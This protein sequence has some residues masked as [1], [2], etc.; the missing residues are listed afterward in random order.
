MKHAIKTELFASRAPLEWAVVGN[1]TLY[2]AQIPIDTQ[3]Q[4]VAGGIEAQARQTLDNLRH[5]LEAA[6]SSLDAVTQ[7]LIYVTDRRYLATVNA[8]YAEYFQAPYP[9]R[10]AV[11]VAGLAREEM[12]VELVVYACL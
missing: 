8:V 2:T 4:V 3:G 9:N 10:A 6:D 11:V 7:V 5:T 1:G 12:L